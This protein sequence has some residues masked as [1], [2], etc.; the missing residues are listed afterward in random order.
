MAK[1]FDSHAHY[2]DSRFASD[3]PG[4]ADALLTN[5]MSGDVGYIINVSTDL[6]DA[7][8]VITQAGKYPGMY[9]AAGIHP[10]DIKNDMKLESEMNKLRSLLSLAKEKKIVAVGEIGLDYYRQPVNKPLQKAFFERQLEIAKEFSLPAVIHDR[11]AHGD[12]LDMI[13]RHPHVRG[14]F[15][16]FSGSAGMAQELLRLG[17]YISFSGVLTF[18]N[19]RKAVE[20]AECVPLDRILI[21]TDCPYLAPHP[22]RGEL[23]HSALMRYTAERLAEIKGLDTDEVIDITAGNAAGL[24][25]IDLV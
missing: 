21:E 6:E 25:G 3:Y 20:A 12:T 10:G 1:L 19:A 8:R 2:T 24:F 5:I 16:S 11:D 13:A 18:K 22:H 23:N 15:H 9:A 14:V 17:W 7:V 4:G